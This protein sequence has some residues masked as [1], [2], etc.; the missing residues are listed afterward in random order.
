MILKLNFVY[1]ENVWK[2]NKFS[3]DV[4]GKHTKLSID[5]QPKLEVDAQ[6]LKSDVK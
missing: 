5:K 3:D 2:L 6:M 4:H 1:R